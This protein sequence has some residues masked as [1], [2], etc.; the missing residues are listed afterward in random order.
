M[1]H[2]VKIAK[3]YAHHVIKGRWPEA[4]PYIMYNPKVASYYA[5]DVIKGRWPEAEPYIMKDPGAAYNYAAHA[6]DGW[7]RWPEAEPYIKKDPVY[8]K[9]YIS[10]FDVPHTDISE[11]LDRIFDL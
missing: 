6:L 8:W 3:R 5:A 10:M 9:L 7:D 4:E 11:S 2:D 1:L